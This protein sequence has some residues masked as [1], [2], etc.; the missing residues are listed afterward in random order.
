MML[1]IISLASLNVDAQTF[2]EWFRQKK[3]QKKY[4]AQQIALYK[5]YGNLLAKGYDI[6]KDGLQLVGDIKNGDFK[7]HDDYFNSL[8][9]V[10]PKV[11]QYT[12]VAQINLYFRRIVQQSNQNLYRVKQSLHT[13]SYQYSYV[14]N[15][16]NNLLAESGDQISLLVDV[17]TDGTLELSE[18]AR[19]EKIE[20]IYESISDM[21]AFCQHFSKGND[22][23]MIQVEKERTDYFLER[24]LHNLE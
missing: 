23:Y 8:K 13:T 11:K 24:R 22:E 6:A 14:S 4:L 20:K 15:V 3:T 16:Y 10:S 5:V 7:L 1:L 19:I 21:Y 18:D 17:L 2:N 9:S 12:K